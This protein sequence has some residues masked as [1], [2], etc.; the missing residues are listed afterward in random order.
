MNGLYGTSRHESVPGLS[1]PFAEIKRRHWIRDS[2]KVIDWMPDLK[3]TLS[4][5][6]SSLQRPTCWYSF[7]FISQLRYYPDRDQ[8]AGTDC[9]SF[10]N[11]F[12]SLFALIPP[13][14]LKLITSNAPKFSSVFE[15]A[16]IKSMWVYAG[17]VRGNP[18]YSIFLIYIHVASDVVHSFG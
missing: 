17:D 11:S 18:G 3:T 4:S 9:V 13:V 12:Q 8:H 1:P 16:D 5:S 15:I 6:S 2:D 7:H 10:L 14:S